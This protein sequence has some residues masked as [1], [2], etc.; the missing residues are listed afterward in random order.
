MIIVWNF[1]MMY[2]NFYW[3]ILYDV[4][5]FYDPISIYVNFNNSVI[6]SKWH[7]FLVRNVVAH[8]LPFRAVFSCDCVHFA[9]PLFSPLCCHH[10]WRPKCRFLTINK[11]L[12]NKVYLSPQSTSREDLTLTHFLFSLPQFFTWHLP[13]KD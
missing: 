4:L 11:G 3:H 9:M 8:D 13:T 5:W 6:F 7:I 2:D 10:F 12:S 1:Y